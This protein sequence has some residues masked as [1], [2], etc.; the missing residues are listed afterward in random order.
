MDKYTKEYLDEIL[1]L[2]GIPLDKDDPN[3]TMVVQ[4]GEVT[5]DDSVIDVKTGKEV[6][7]LNIY[8]K[9]NKKDDIVPIY[10]VSLSD[11]YTMYARGGAAF[12]NYKKK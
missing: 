5:I 6:K 1:P 10:I 12:R 3:C 8:L 2:S 7:V 11:G 4:G 9:E